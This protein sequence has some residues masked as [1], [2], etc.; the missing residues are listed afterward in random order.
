VPDVLDQPGLGLLPGE[1]V[2]V[3]DRGQRIGRGLRW[4]AGVNEELL[5]WVPGE[6]ARY[7]ALGGV[8]LGTATIAA[9]SMTMAL[10]E[11]LGGF[12][13]MILLPVLIWGVF[14]A[15][16]DRWLVSTS[17]VGR[18]GKRAGLLLPRLGLA[19]AFGMVIAEPLVLKVFE[20]AIEEHIHQERAT[21]VATLEGA[22]TRCNPEPTADEEAR[23]AASGL[24]C[25]P[26]QLGLEAG[27]AA[28]QQDV[29]AKRLT[30][31]GLVRTIAT[32]SDEQARRDTLASNECSGTPGPGSTGTRGRGPECKAREAEAAA[33]RESHPTTEHEEQLAKLQGE[34]NT[35]EAKLNTAQQD[36][37]AT[38]STAIEGKVDELRAS[39]GS[40][41]LLERFDALEEL[42]SDNPFLSVVTWFIR[43]F[44]IAIDC[45]P[46][47]VK[48]ISGTSRYDELVELHSISAQKVYGQSVRTMEKALLDDLRGRQH[49]TTNA[50]DMA[51]SETDHRRRLHEAQLDVDLDRHV[52]ALAAQLRGDPVY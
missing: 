27:F 25:R 52:A 24:D 31:D 26:Y 16:L 41:G 2:V 42:T 40:I 5:S 6:R 46:V 12:H 28:I 20:S 43:L 37:A 44:F 3:E 47:V 49:E 48:F 30:A 14:V 10:T 23:E 39:H 36:Y 45:L 50:A 21:E 13:V 4:F 7:T 35:L 18:W 34:I 33:Y 38:R 32:E 17:T 1:R 29:D 9:F 22:F 51:R 19:F 8:V 11:V 15:N